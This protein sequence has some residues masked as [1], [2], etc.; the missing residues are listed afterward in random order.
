MTLFLLSYKNERLVKSKSICEIFIVGYTKY[1][2]KR[3]ECSKQ[4]KWK[5][6]KF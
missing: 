5:T 4:E 1:I 6:F 3:N 2:D